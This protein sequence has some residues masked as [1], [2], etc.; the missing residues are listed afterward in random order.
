MFS[1]GERSGLQAGHFSTMPWCCNRHSMRYRW[2]HMLILNFHKPFS[3]YCAFKVS[4]FTYL[5]CFLCFIVEKNMDLL[6]VPTFSGVRL[7]IGRRR[8]TFGGGRRTWGSYPTLI[9]LCFC[10]S[11]QFSEEKENTCRAL[12]KNLIH[13]DRLAQTWTPN[14][15]RDNSAKHSLKVKYRAD[16]TCSV[17]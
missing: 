10:L 3:I 2:V 8:A 5:T 7:I 16:Y 13:L 17:S 4:R 11:I 12:N 6:V 9:S 14:T 1:T 15:C